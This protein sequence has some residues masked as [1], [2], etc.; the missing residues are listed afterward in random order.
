MERCEYGK[1]CNL[2]LTDKYTKELSYTVTHVENEYRVMNKSIMLD[3]YETMENQSISEEDPLKLNRKCKIYTVLG[4]LDVM[5]NKRHLMLA[6]L[7]IVKKV[8]FNCFRAISIIDYYRTKQIKKSLSSSPISSTPSS[9]YN[10]LP[11]LCTRSSFKNLEIQ[12]V[13][14]KQAINKFQRRLIRRSIEK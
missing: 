14:P 10:S 9:N 2:D 3:R 7:Y 6:N 5:E 12:R 8:C 13:L 4:L 1:Y 11:K